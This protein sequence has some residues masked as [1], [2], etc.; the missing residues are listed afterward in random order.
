MTKRGRPSDYTKEK[1]E[2]ICDRIANGE[3]IRKIC[4]DDHMP[5]GATF[6]KWL[7]DFPDFLK[8]YEAAKQEQAEA[9][10]AEMV[11]IA[12]NLTGDTQRDRLRVDTRLIF[13]VDKANLYFMHNR[14]FV[15]AGMGDLFA[16]FLC[17]EF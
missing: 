4:A 5:A 10:V 11:D 2:E 6:F 16:V 15:I 3:S 13:R 12:D 7:R 9:F 8:Q 17:L 14:I 1:A